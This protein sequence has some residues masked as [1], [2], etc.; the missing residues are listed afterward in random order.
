M[1]SNIILKNE[2]VQSGLLVRPRPNNGES[3][4]AYVGRVA[5]SNAM[6]VSQLLRLV[7]SDS[8]FG[9]WQH[10]HQRLCLEVTD[11]AILI[12]P[13]PQSW[14]VTS[15]L[16]GIATVEFN[17]LHRRWC[18]LCL[19][20]ETYFRGIWG[21]KL[22]CV[23]IS[24]ACYLIAHCG[25]CRQ[26]QSWQSANLFICM[27]CGA[28]LQRFSTQA[29]TPKMVTLQRAL[30]AN[31]IGT[32]SEIFA[33]LDTNAWIRLIRY[34]GQF[35]GVEL[36]KRPGQI[37]ALHRL[38]V[39]K[40]CM[41]N[42]AHL[43]GDWP[44][45]FEQLLQAIQT[46]LPPTSSLKK[47]FGV[48]YHVLYFHLRDACYQ[49][50]RDAFENY[51]HQ[52]W[53]GMVCKRNRAFKST[54]IAAHPRLTLHDAAKKTGVA[55]SLIKHLSTSKAINKSNIYLPSGRQ[56]SSFH[57]AD[58]PHIE[59]LAKD[60]LNLQATAQYLAVSERV[61]RELIA[62]KVITPLA[63]RTHANMANW[64]I[65]KQQLQR[66]FLMASP[67]QN[68][69]L[70]SFSWIVK[71]CRLRE[72]EMVQLAKALISSELKAFDVSGH[73]VILGKA[74]LDKA[75]AK[76]WLWSLRSGLDTMSIDEAAKLL[77]VKQQV[78]Y[79]LVKIGLIH[80]IQTKQSGKQI[81]KEDLAT[82]NNN[83]VALSVLAKKQQTSPFALF[84]SLKIKPVTGPQIDGGRQY[85]YLKKHFAT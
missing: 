73:S 82:F 79:Y 66:L 11:T 75:L 74:K 14:Q 28:S 38:E 29:A 65:P 69:E 85:F 44:I 68:E 76:D 3:S 13:L 67:K 80:S 30:V 55:P 4:L 47:T 40:D 33:E 31:L 81:T 58:L 25:Q 83:Y 39:A 46:S 5:D 54:T 63:I 57:Q 52:H 9:H 59:A 1:L 20:E 34:L 7:A 12:G 10:L 50:L 62:A 37:S 43:L 70:V 6:E 78:A 27:H 15:T 45:N 77:G 60:L 17:H 26:P 19:Q 41:H 21:L 53:W 61:V 71:Y 23:C 32:R 84:K 56:V 24:H 18:P 49:F 35:K 72:G 16:K 48:L 22:S 2:V 42:V 64:L 51:L 36:P 8:I